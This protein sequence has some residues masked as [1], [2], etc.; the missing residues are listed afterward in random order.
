MQLLETSVFGLRAARHRLTSPDHPA[1][2]TLFPMVHVGE[3]A[4]FDRVAAEALSHDVVLV[5]GVQARTAHLLT[6]A[7]AWA[8]LARL[9]LV[10]QGRITPD[11][12]GAEIVLADVT[13]PEFETLWRNVPVWLRMAF[14]LGAP[15][16]GLWLKLTATRRSLIRHL[17][18]DDLP[19]RDIALMHDTAA[20]RPLNALLHARDKHLRMV[21]RH[22][23]DRARDTR[24]R[25]AVVYGA[26]HMPAVLAELRAHG[27]F[28]PTESA[29]LDAIHL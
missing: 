9:G 22:Q 28:R 7:Y 18:Q 10:V 16:Y 2:V 6:R 8:P 25:I 15:L 11:G 29:W 14:T 26:A 3:A 20:E 23:L 17:A 5:E 12:G 24:R 19:D 21:L 27:D 1:E 4:F 13:G